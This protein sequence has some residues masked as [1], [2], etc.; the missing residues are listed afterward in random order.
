M[1]TVAL[2]VSGLYALRPILSNDIA[3]TVAVETILQ[4]P[5]PDYAMA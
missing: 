4:T 5:S 2:W 1:N 3:A